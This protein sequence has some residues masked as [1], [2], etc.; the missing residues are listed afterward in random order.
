MNVLLQNFSLTTIILAVVDWIENTLI[1][2]FSILVNLAGAGLRIHY[3]F[4]TA[5]GLAKIHLIYT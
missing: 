4:C 5:K 1:P 2:S 3:E